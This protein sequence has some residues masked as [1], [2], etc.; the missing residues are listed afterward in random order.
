M[1]S[2]PFGSQIPTEFYRTKNSNETKTLKISVFM[3]LKLTEFKKPSMIV[4]IV[5]EMVK[6]GGKKW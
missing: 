6:K 4:K 5:K 1:G 2:M 3:N